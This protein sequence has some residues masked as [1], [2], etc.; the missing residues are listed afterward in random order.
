[1][2]KLISL[3]T[4]ALMLTLASA[5]ASATQITGTIEFAG[6]ST[7]EATDTE[8]TS[9][10]FG[11]ALV[12]TATGTF[13][14]EGLVGWSTEATFTDL[15]LTSIDSID[16]LW[17]ALGFSFDLVSIT[18]NEVDYDDNGDVVSVTVS[19][20]GYISYDGYEDTLY[21]WIYTNQAGGS[22]FSATSTSVPAP[23]GAALLGLALL[24]FGTFRRKKA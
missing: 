24:G 21:S 23:A 19:G 22:T 10:D 20:T 7:Y 16:S 13:A 15:D 5:T 17:T 11:D 1:M 18:D 3:F 4:M 9:I 12:T 8:V 14:D 2:K 6:S